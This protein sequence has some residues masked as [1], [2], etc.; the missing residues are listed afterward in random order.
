MSMP[1]EV[2]VWRRAE[3]ARLIA[4]RMAL[5]TAQRRAARERVR[6]TLAAEVPELRGAT[7]GF[8]W[9]FRG[10]IDLV[11]LVRELTAVLPE[12]AVAAQRYCSV[13]ALATSQF[14]WPGLRSSST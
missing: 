10:E 3:R 13:T 2:K 1:G 9:P 4:T 7:I 6:A 8:Y 5:T 12:R 14:T 11:G